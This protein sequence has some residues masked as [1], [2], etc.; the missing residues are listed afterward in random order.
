MF[1]T[2]YFN[3]HGL[4]FDGNHRLFNCFDIRRQIVQR[5]LTSIFTGKTTINPGGCDSEVSSCFLA[6]AHMLTDRHE[7]YLD[8]H[9]GDG[10]AMF[11][12]TVF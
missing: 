12:L 11:L 6:E 1:S 5:T 2:K 8:L 7:L 3:V 9:V 10:E 4:K